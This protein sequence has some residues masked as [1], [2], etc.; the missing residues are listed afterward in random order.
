VALKE[1]ILGALQGDDSALKS[2]GGAKAKKRSPAEVVAGLTSAQRSM[3]RARAE[4]IIEAIDAYEAEN[5]EE[6]S[7]AESV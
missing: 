6:E 1:D 7:D 3:L 5:E 4:E 2:K